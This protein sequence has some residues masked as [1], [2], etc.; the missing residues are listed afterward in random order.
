MNERVFA[1]RLLVAMGNALTVVSAEVPKFRVS[2][3]LGVPERILEKAIAE[4]SIVLLGDLYAL[5]GNDQV[6]SD[7][8][9][10]TH[11]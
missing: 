4:V 7:F 11:R 6:R 8:F 10:D 3:T 5:V 1:M 2:S 9:I